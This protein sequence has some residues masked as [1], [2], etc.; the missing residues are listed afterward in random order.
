MVHRGYRGDPP[1]PFH[2]FHHFFKITPG[3]LDGYASG[4]LKSSYFSHPN[5][6]ILMA[7]D[8]LL[9]HGR[10]NSPGEVTRSF[11]KPVD[12]DWSRL[13]DLSLSVLNSTRDEDT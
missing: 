8:P 10:P 7:L 2:P 5:P 13:K 9:S 3:S 4:P 6:K 1:L 12:S 11:H